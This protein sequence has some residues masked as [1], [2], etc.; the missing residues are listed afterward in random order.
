[1][2]V[3][4]SALFRN[5]INGSVPPNKRTARAPD[6]KS[7]KQHLLNHWPKF[8]IISQNCSSWCTLPKFH[9]WFHSTDQS[10][11]GEQP[12]ALLFDFRLVNTKAILAFLWN[13]LHISPKLLY[14]TTSHYRPWLHSASRLAWQWFKFY[15]TPWP[16]LKVGSKVK[17]LKFTVSCQY[18]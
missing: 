13:E 4:H 12:R 8:I 15:P 6:K 2:N 1:M 5:C 10:F 14:L 3:P 9:K 17:Y 7:F 16:F 18:F 11:S